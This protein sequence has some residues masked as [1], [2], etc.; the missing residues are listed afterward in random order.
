MYLGYD[1][2]PK[3]LE[4]AGN[5]LRSATLYVQ[6]R[7]LGILWTNNQSKV[8]PEFIPGTIKPIRTFTFGAR[9]GL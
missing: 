3:L 6:A 2:S 7:N 4:R 5:I 9:I 8:D 1:L